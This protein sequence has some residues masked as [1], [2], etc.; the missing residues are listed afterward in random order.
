MGGQIQ[1]YVPTSRFFCIFIH[2]PLCSKY[3]LIVAIYLSPSR[4]YPPVQAKPDDDRRGQYLRGGKRQPH[5]G[6]AA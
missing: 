4:F 1:E 6:L 3:K 5:T 2:P